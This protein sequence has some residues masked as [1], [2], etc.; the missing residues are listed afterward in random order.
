MA[1]AASPVSSILTRAA[2]ISDVDAL[3]GLCR[4]MT[5]ITYTASHLQERLSAANGSEIILVAYAEALV[6]GFLC[7]DVRRPL[8]QEADTF[9]ITCLYVTSAWQG[10]GIAGQLIANLE[11]RARRQGAADICLRVDICNSEM[12]GRYTVAGFVARPQQQ[13]WSK[14]LR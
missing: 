9:E 3:A 2:D 5:G 8:C 12:R 6:V 1:L 11:D 13:L 10:R 14:R 4:E 7:C